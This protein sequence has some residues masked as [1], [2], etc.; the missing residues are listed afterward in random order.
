[1]DGW[2]LAGVGVRKKKGPVSASPVFDLNNRV[3]DGA[4]FG[5]R[6]L[7]GSRL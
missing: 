3:D 4:V 1:M 5:D 7:E 6:G 2:C